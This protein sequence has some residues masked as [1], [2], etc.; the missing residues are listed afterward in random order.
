MKKATHRIYISIIV[1]LMATNISLYIGKT[2]A[3][4]EDPE[5][6][7]AISEDSADAGISVKEKINLNTATI[8]QLD[9]IDGIGPA[10]ATKIIER[11]EELG[12]FKSIDDLLSVKGI[13]E[14]KLSAIKEC[15]YV[16]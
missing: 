11:R 10:T 6:A 5:P 7:S 2:G 3:Y 16:S 4:V 1:L 15:A 12:G 14:K 9:T 13:G 8:D